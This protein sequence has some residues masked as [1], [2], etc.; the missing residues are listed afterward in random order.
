MSYRD[1]FVKRFRIFSP[2][3]SRWVLLASLLTVVIF[4][5]FGLMASLP[6]ALTSVFLMLFYYDPERDLPSHPLAVMSPVDGK[7]IGIGSFHDPFLERISQ[8]I[9]IKANLFRVYQARSPT[10]GKMME[11]W[12]AISV[13]RPGY[14]K[15]LVKGAWWIRTDEGDDVVMVVRSRSFFGRTYCGAQAG[16]R[17]GQ[18]RRC[19]R[20]PVFCNIDILI[21]EHSF[22]EVQEGQ[23]VQAGIHS[24]ATFN[25]DE[26]DAGQV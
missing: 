7:V 15:Q 12:P 13:D 14:T 16:E 26:R 23:S 1:F 17:I 6:F 3:G 8:R 19:G 5:Q 24:L 21:S 11:Y 25:H 4:F 10:E 2:D 18:A 20:F 22:I 9:R